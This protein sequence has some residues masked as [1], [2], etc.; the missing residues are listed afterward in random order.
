MNKETTQGKLMYMAVGD[1]ILSQIA[2]GEL[3][4]GDRLDK[5]QQLARRMNVGEGT[6]RHALQS[7]AARGFV[8]RRP[9]VGTIVSRVPDERIDQALQ[10]ATQTTYALIVPDIRNPQFSSLA[11]GDSF[12]NTYTAMHHLIERGYRTIGFISNAMHH[13]AFK[14][15]PE[16]VV[17]NQSDRPSA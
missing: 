14:S 2:S 1:A 6:V 13:P 3:K 4:P 9:R 12:E 11:R 8:E 17:F 7:L 10:H 16:H 15:R 5:P